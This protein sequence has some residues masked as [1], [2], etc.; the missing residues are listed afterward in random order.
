MER[1]KVYPISMCKKN[2]IRQKTVAEINLPPVD[3]TVRLAGEI[4]TE[5]DSVVTSS[6]RLPTTI[7]KWPQNYKKKKN[8]AASLPGRTG[9]TLSFE[10]NGDRKVA[11]HLPFIPLLPAFFYKQILKI[12]GEK[13]ATIN[14]LLNIKKT[15]CSILH[16]LNV[17]RQTDYKI[18]DQQLY[19]INPHYETKFGLTP[20]KLNR[21]ISHIPYLRDFLSTSCFYILKK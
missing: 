2:I 1:V 17:A 21:L 14:E 16:F 11:S 3:T 6:K 8:I 9:W 10:Y 19:F 4:V 13:D 7:N 15:G 20:R 18:I 5:T 12:L